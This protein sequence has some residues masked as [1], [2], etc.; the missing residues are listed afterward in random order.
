ME[1]IEEEKTINFIVDLTL[2]EGI[3]FTLWWPAIIN[4]GLGVALKNTKQLVQKI[5]NL[6]R[7]ISNYMF[8]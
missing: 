2:L 3:T 6:I 5:K 7:I 4:N 8:N 1:K